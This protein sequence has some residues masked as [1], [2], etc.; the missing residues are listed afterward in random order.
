MDPKYAI[1]QL[2]KEIRKAG[3]TKRK[4]PKSTGELL[5]IGFRLKKN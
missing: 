1:L 4:N 2:E 5:E 3:D